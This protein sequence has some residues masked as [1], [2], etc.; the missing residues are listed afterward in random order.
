MK[1]NVMQLTPNQKISCLPFG[2]IALGKLTWL[3]SVVAA[4][5]WTAHSWATWPEPHDSRWKLWGVG[6]GWF[7]GLAGMIWGKWR[8]R[9][10]AD[11]FR[12]LSGYQI[13]EA[14]PKPVKALVKPTK[15][16]NLTNFRKAS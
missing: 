12:R 1:G 10:C 9:V 8:Q 3:A 15:P 2:G 14:Q 13:P 16:A 11:M 5:I 6:I 4:M 7:Y